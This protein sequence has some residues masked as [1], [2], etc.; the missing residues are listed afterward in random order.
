LLLVRLLL[1]ITT[2][3]LT[4]WLLGW[5]LRCAGA[6]LRSLRTFLL[7]LLLLEHL[8]LPPPGV[9]AEWLDLLHC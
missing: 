6:H 2:T 3:Q 8:L 4:H 1:L 7:L 9:P 5:L